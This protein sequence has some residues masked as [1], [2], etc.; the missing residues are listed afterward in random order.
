MLQGTK[1]AR[2]RSLSPSN[3]RIKKPVNVVGPGPRNPGYLACPTSQGKYDTP[4]ATYAHSRCFYDKP[5]ALKSSAMPGSH[6]TSFTVK[7]FCVSWPP[8]AAW[9]AR[10]GSNP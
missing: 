6:F 7:N 2:R 3:Q 1:Y 4:R 8:P 9:R 10:P 5:D